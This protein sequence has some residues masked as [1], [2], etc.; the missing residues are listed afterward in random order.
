IIMTILNPF[1][2]GSVSFLLSA[3][4]TAGI[5]VLYP[6]LAE[7]YDFKNKYLSAV[8]RAVLVSLSAVICTAPITL[9]FFGTVNA[10]AII[11][12]VLVSLP[13][14][15][16]LTIGAT[17]T[18]ISFIPVIGGVAAFPLFIT[19]ILIK[20]FNFTVNLFG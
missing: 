13:V 1:I 6:F 17:A 8:W 18:L 20:Y 14:T 5:L 2:F 12:S 10:T 16:A 7:K 15:L 19:D 3:S 4:A 9:I 11:T